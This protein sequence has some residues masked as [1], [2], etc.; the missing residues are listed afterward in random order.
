MHLSLSVSSRPVSRH[1]LLTGMLLTAEIL[2]ASQCTTSEGTWKWVLLL[3]HLVKA[4]LA[5]FLQRTVTF[6]SS[7]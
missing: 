1:A 2:K 3:D 4:K 6:S 5:R 7:L